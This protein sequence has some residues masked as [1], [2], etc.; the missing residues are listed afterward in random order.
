[1]LSYQSDALDPKTGMTLKELSEFVAAAYTI[2]HNDDSTITG[3]ITM[4]GRIKV[5]TAER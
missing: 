3:L 1:M 4:R 5:L 2:G